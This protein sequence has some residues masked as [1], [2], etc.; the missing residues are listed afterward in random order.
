MIF[1]PLSQD[2]RR[3]FGTAVSLTS[4]ENGRALIR[5]MPQD[6]WPHTPYDDQVET[7]AKV[8][9]GTDILVLLP[10]GI[11]KPAMWYFHVRVE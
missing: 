2:L 9:D 6:L 4:P 11:G 1:C 5:Q 8:L 10:T 3:N 7:A